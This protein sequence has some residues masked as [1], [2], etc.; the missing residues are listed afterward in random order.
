MKNLKTYSNFLN[1]SLD[2][3]TRDQESFLA[4]TVMGTYTFDDRT[5]LVNVIGNVIVVNRHLKS[6][7]VDKFPVEFG[8]VTGNFDCSGCDRLTTLHGAPQRVR[9]DFMGN[10]CF[11]LENLM[12]SPRVV[13]KN[14]SVAGCV[15]LKSLKGSP[16]KVFGNY[17]C[18]SCQKL[19]TLEGMTV[20]VV[21]NRYVHKCELPADEF[22]M[23]SMHREMFVEW[24]KTGTSF[25]EFCGRSRGKIKGEKFG[26]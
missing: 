22:N 6:L 9:G 13:L 19:T 8:D 26:I 14:F 7:N 5:G 17:S 11:G 3:L 25:H 2:E 12:G 21:G 20:E 16:D 23:F 10:R 15:N 18:T 4:S 1:E 24:L